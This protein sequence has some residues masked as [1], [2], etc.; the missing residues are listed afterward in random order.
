M[1]QLLPELLQEKC[2][3]M[4]F[5]Q[6]T[7]IQEKIFAPIT[8]QESLIAISPTGTGKTL[9]YLLPIITKIEANHQL[10]VIILAPSQE[11]VSQI[12]RVA[13]EWAAV[14]NLKVLTIVGG[15]NV[16]RQVE[17]L[18]QKVEIII[19]T[20]GRLNELMDKT[21]K[22]KLHEVTTI[23]YDEADYLFNEEHQATVLKIRKRL[24]RDIQSIWVSATYGESLQQLKATHPN[25]ALWQ[26]NQHNQALNIQHWL[27]TTNNRQKAQQLRKLA[28]VDGMRAI[29][30]FEQVNELDDVAAKLAY[31]QLRVV[32]LHSQLSKMERESAIRRFANGDA[33]YMLTTDVAA[34]GLDIDDV[35]YVIHYNKVS[36]VETYAHRS[37][38]T[39]RMGK[40]GNVISLANEQEA[41]DLQQLLQPNGFQLLPIYLHSAQLLMEK[42]ENVQLDRPNKTSHNATKSHSA[43]KQSKIQ[44]SA[45]ELSKSKRKKNRTRDTKNKGKRRTK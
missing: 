17:A 21:R 34:R 26:V 23:V 25:I 39:G 44:Q 30:F 33:V 2:R 10:Q 16:K 36:D 22:L 12:A 24:M 20:P 14:L 1:S 31:H 7:D 11:L 13:E 42:P 6:L 41:R 37:G 28:Q 19:A 5:E 15:A 3:Q 18:K 43:K 8:Q 4:G 40:V 45:S 35:M 9:A 38:R 27:L 29:V 32:S